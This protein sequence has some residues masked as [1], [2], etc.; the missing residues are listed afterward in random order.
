M[1][2][3]LME[4]VGKLVFW[5]SLYLHLYIVSKVVCVPVIYDFAI[6]EPAPR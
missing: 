5:S 3:L 2:V 1:C 4:H 6:I